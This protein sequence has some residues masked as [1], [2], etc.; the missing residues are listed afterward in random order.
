F[1]TNPPLNLP[2]APVARWR[3]DGDHVAATPG[4]ILR[5]S[6]TGRNRGRF[7]ALGEGVRRLSAT[8]PPHGRDTRLQIAGS[9]PRSGGPAETRPRAPRRS[10]RRRSPRRRLAASGEARAWR[11]GRPPAR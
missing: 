3:P 11:F 10:R 2:L 4:H 5:Q 9:P 6:V 8:P 7:A 1:P